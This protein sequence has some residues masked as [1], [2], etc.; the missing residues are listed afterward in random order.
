MT[1]LQVKD[2]SVLCSQIDSDRLYQM[3]FK[4]HYLLGRKRHIVGILL[5]YLYLYQTVAESL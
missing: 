4:I 1:K 2:H 5:G 3:Y